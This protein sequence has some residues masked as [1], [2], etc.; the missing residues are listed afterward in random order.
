[1]Q[2]LGLGHR[3]KRSLGDAWPI[4]VLSAWLGAIEAG[5]SSFDANQ[6]GD[7]S[8][9]EN[10]SVFIRVRSNGSVS[11]SSFLFLQDRRG[12]VLELTALCSVVR[13]H[14]VSRLRH[15]HF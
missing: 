1:M 3:P 4:D 14:A 8:I 2:P 6:I 11:H 13:F 10:P 12:I 9:Q 7:L 5:E 15:C